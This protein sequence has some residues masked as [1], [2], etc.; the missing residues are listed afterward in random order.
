MPCFCAHCGK[1]LPNHAD[2]CPVKTNPILKAFHDH[3]LFNQPK[4][5]PKVPAFLQAK[6]ALP[7]PAAAGGP[8]TAKEAAA[9][10]VHM[11]RIPKPVPG[12]WCVACQRQAVADSIILDEDAPDGLRALSVK[13]LLGKYQAPTGRLMLEADA[14]VVWMLDSQALMDDDF[15]DVATFIRGVLM[16]ADRC[17]LVPAKGAAA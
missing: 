7:K 1:E 11:P 13:L 17:R 5:P 9:G 15:P 10:V 4:E 3:V 12:C 16:V 8:I 2:S 6:C 14:G